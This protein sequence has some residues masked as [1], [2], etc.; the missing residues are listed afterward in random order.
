M[1]YTGSKRR[2]VILILFALTIAALA[3]GIFC[4]C[5]YVDPEQ[6]LIDRG[7]IHLVTYDAA[8]G[9]F[10]ATAAQ[11]VEEGQVRVMDNSLTVEPGYRHI[12]AGDKDYLPAP[13]RAGYDLAGWMLVTTDGETETLTPWDFL[14]DRVT[15]DI[16]LR[17]NWAKRGTLRICAQ[18]GGETAEFLSYS[19]TAG[20]EILSYLYDTT[21]AGDYLLRED[22]VRNNVQKYD[23]KS[24]TLLRYYWDAEHTVPVTEENAVYEEGA[25]ERVLYADCLEG[26][27]R[28]MNR[29]EVS[30][31]ERLAYNSHW[32]LVED[33]DFA[34]V[35]IEGTLGSF[36][37]VILGNGH[38][39]SNMTFRTRVWRNGTAPT[40]SIFGEMTGTV[41]N[42]TF[43]NVQL[44]VYSRYFDSLDTSLAIRVAFL[45]DSFGEEGA[46]IDTQLKECKISI[47]NA[48]PEGKEAKFTYTLGAADDAAHRYYW[49]EDPV[50]KQ[51]V[52]GTIA[53]DDYTDEDL[54][55]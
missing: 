15:S 55:M 49:S 11:P 9:S 51:S 29:A 42:V 16:T 23:G 22:Y 47:V 32:Y 34:G 38:T 8:G 52:T 19:V 30:G 12:G 48:H 54:I 44:M 14:R 46:F 40:R 43:D 53:L 45:A 17:A 31:G 1:K 35:E 28:I 6:D 7:Y 18:I 10:D 25:E 3:A 13:V 2:N 27:F 39:I 24:Y 41:Q 26:E 36:S 37:G 4:A 20:S 21:D 33:L 50:A 5:S